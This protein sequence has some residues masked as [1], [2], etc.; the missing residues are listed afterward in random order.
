MRYVPIILLPVAVVVGF[1]GYSIETSVSS[2]KTPY[3]DHSI[4]E[5]R[6][7]RLLKEAAEGTLTGAS[8]NRSSYPS[9]FDKNNAASLKK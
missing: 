5:E 3:P 6:E 8:I 2:R 9:I 1:I 4:N 7:K